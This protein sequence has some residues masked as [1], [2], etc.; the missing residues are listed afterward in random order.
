MEQ[1]DG[2]I[3]LEL[4]LGKISLGSAVGQQLGKVTM[5]RVS[6]GPSEHQLGKVNMG[7]LHQQ[8]GKIPLGE[9]EPPKLQR[10]MAGESSGL[11]TAEPLQQRSKSLEE[12][13][14]TK[15]IT[16]QPHH[17]SKSLEQP[18]ERR[19]PL[20]QPPP[21]RK[22]TIEEQMCHMAEQKQ[23]RRQ[24]QPQRGRSMS[25][26]SLT[27]VK[28]R[29][30]FSFRRRTRSLRVRPSVGT[31]STAAQCEFAPLLKFVYFYG[32]IIRNIKH[33]YVHSCLT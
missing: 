18:M 28:M 24:Q 27:F 25:L 13:K 33:E 16:Q 1:V 6:V 3:S 26:T 32:A 30:L 12:T 31:C 5:G 21:P 19:L 8:L 10:Q 15:V 23:Q 17:R 11:T 4:Q 2:A 14:H 9:V 29:K 22:V 20:K 7:A